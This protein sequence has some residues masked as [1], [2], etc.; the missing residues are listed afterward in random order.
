[1]AWVMLAALLALTEEQCGDD[2]VAALLLAERL[3]K[4]RGGQRK[5]EAYMRDPA[6]REKII[7]QH[8]RAAE[9]LGLGQTRH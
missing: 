9:M 4:R 6:N 5:L 7:D 3:R 8:R 2:N 1:M